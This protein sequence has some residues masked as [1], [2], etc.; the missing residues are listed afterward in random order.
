MQCTGEAKPPTEVHEQVSVLKPFQFLHINILREYLAHDLRVNDLPF[1][2]ELER[3]IDDFVFLCFFVGNDFLPHLPSLEIREGAIERLC[4][5]YKRLLPSMGGYVSEN[6]VLDMSRVDVLLSELGMVED[7]ILKA[8]KVREEQWRARE[9][10]KMEKIKRIKEERAGA[11]N[12]VVKFAEEQ[13]MRPVR[14]SIHDRKRK[15]TEEEGPTEQAAH[16]QGA[17]EKEEEKAVE[18]QI[19]SDGEPEKQRSSS[20]IEEQKMKD[21]DEDGQEAEDEVGE[22]GGE[23]EADD[24]G[25]DKAERKR[26]KVALTSDEDGMQPAKSETDT[27]PVKKEKN[28]KTSKK[29]KRSANNQTTATES[30]PAATPMATSPATVEADLAAVGDA[31][32]SEDEEEDPVAVTPSPLKETKHI[33]E[34]ILAAAPEPTG[35]PQTDFAAL[36][37]ARLKDIAE[38][39]QVEDQIRFGEDGWKDR[40]YAVKMKVSTEREEDMPMLRRLFTSYAEGLAWVMLYYYRGCAS[41]SW[42]YPFHYAPM[43][44]DLRNLDRF[45]QSFELSAPFTPMGQLMGVLP[46]ASSHCMPEACREL[47]LNP[48]SPIADFYPEDFPLDL[49]GKKYLWQAVA[50]LP[51]IDEK[52]LLT[53]LRKVEPSFTAEEKDRNDVGEEYLFV[54]SSHR[55]ANTV[56]ALHLRHSGKLKKLKRDEREQLKKELNAADSSGLFG[57]I[58]P[59]SGAITPG[60]TLRSTVGLELLTKLPVVSCVLYLAPEAEH[61]SAL[62]EGLIP[63][64][65][66]LSEHDLKDSNRGGRREQPRLGENAQFMSNQEHWARQQQ[67]QQQQQQHQQQQQQ[68][69]QQG[70]AGVAGPYTIRMLAAEQGNG[71]YNN[72]TYPYMQQADAPAPTYSGHSYYDQFIRRD[73]QQQQ[74]QQ[75][76][77]QHQPPPNSY[78]FPPPMPPNTSNN[79]TS[80]Y[81]PYPNPPYPYHQPSYPPTPY[82][83]AHPSYQPQPP[84]YPYGAAPPGQPY[85]Y[86]APPMPYT[87][88][89][90]GGGRGEAGSVQGSG[91]VPP[92]PYTFAPGG[93]GAGGYGSRR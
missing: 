78:Y 49:N 30:Q 66:V 23:E 32:S 40:Y 79:R 61:R 60:S 74:Q 33:T 56:S 87:F 26:R 18:A 52:R 25:T 65:A 45:K 28:D 93:A 37:N 55:I 17:E 11:I 62:L 69:Q 31:E 72:N 51:W 29:A 58:A 2:W 8:R 75:Q 64:P 12:K 22:Q 77:Q 16:Q 5:I 15:A 82:Y 67:Q 9:R 20:S 6:G 14:G 39:A 91:G 88:S 83:P 7:N 43:A 48:H 3:V 53:E 59:Y 84:A 35:D 46:A 24:R 90:G 41:W 44:G 92:M 73:T 63:P 13:G 68:Q 71:A 27:P 36:L 10:E 1:E 81:P 42:Y 47:M 86:A 76:P 38:P 21:E 70:A 34:K 54:H 50:L 19:E 57:F 80:S 85:S 4:G 89:K